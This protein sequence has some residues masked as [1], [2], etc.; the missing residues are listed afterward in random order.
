MGNRKQTHILLLPRLGR[1]VNQQGIEGQRVGED[2][3]SN[4][5]AADTEAVESLRFAVPDRH[6]DRFEVRV[7]G[8]V[9]ACAW[10]GLASRREGR[11]GA[12]GGLQERLEGGGRTSDGTVNDC[13]VLELDRD[14]LV[15]ELHLSVPKTKS[16]SSP[17]PRVTRPFRRR[18]STYEEP[19]DKER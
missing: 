4:V 8:H 14:R 12:T 5:V 15:V 7:H 1:I 13:T 16:I 9:D 17:I 11:L 3:V 10:D 18:S 6:L 2:K 19:A